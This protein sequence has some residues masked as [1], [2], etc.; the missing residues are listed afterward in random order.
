M[1]NFKLKPLKW[2][3]DKGLDGR[4]CRMTAIADTWDELH[5]SDEEWEQHVDNQHTNT[6]IYNRYDVFINMDE[7]RN[8]VIKAVFIGNNQPPTVVSTFDEGKTLCEQWH[9]EFWTALM[10]DIMKNIM[11]N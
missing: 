1:D 11:D 10:T 8:E 5:C 9:K 6:R 4:V 3:I 7:N 2:H